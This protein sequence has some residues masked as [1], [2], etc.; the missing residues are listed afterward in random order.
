ML[1]TVATTAAGVVAGSFLFQGIQGLMGH[2]GPGESAKALEPGG[3]NAM[4]PLPESASG[5]SPI[6][7]EA[8]GAADESPDY[9]A[10]DGGDGG[11]GDSGDAA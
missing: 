4:Q 10:S 7:A 11:S 6:E 8:A 9:A 3:A 2:H 5:F 1:G